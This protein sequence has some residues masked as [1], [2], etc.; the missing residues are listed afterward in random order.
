LGA[1]ESAHVLSYGP[2]IKKWGKM[3]QIPG[4]LD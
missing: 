4:D 1:V 2:R 3:F